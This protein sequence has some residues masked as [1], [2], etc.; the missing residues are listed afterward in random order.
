MLW[1][2][3]ASEA[4]SSSCSGGAVHNYHNAAHYCFF[5]LT[6]HHHKHKMTD[7]ED[8]LRHVSAVMVRLWTNFAATGNPTPDDD[9]ANGG[10]ESFLILSF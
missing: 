10:K 9:D 6:G 5:Q 2:S 8:V 4:S 7:A 1:Q 3:F